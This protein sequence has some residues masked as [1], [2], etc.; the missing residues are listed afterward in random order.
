M[1]MTMVS[2]P[3]IRNSQNQPGLPPM[4]RISKIPAAKSAEITRATSR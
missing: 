1:E 2:S 3:S 4:P